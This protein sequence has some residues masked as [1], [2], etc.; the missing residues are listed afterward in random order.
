MN[1]QW[2]V[3]YVPVRSD[4]GIGYFL[5]CA[6]FGLLAIGLFLSQGQKMSLNLHNSNQY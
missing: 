5:W 2:Y 4:L 1:C 3:F 6:S